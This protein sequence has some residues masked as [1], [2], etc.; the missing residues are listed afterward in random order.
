[1]AVFETLTELVVRIDL[2]TDFSD[3][4]GVVC[5]DQLADL[6]KPALH[7]EQFCLGHAV[8]ELNVQLY[9][10]VLFLGEF[11]FKEF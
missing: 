4:R 6:L 5:L 10:V 2:V 7:V 11:A 1:M 8:P 9:S 3:Q